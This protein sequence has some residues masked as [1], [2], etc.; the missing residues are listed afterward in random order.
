MNHY[1][2]EEQFGAFF[3]RYMPLVRIVAKNKDIPVDEIDDFV[4]DTFAAYFFH[5]PIDWPEGQVKATL[6]K[7]VRNLCVDYYRKQEARPVTYYDPATI[8][9]LICWRSQKYGRDNLSIFLEHQELEEVIHALSEMRED[10]VQVIMLNIIEGRPM[11][12]VSEILDISSDACRARLSRG[13]KHLRKVLSPEEPEKY[14]PC[15]RSK[16]SF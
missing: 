10:W 1:S 8:Q 11:S 12:E 4:Q 7:I 14:R 9:E 15:G 16:A 6:S 13:R 5:Y 2:E 3:K